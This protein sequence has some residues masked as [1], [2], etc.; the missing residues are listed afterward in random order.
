MYFQYLTVARQ[1]VSWAR[2][3]CTDGLQV[4]WIASAGGGSVS[5]LLAIRAKTGDSLRHCRHNM[6]DS[7]YDEFR[8]SSVLAISRGAEEL[9]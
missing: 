3:G 5:P 4:K 8:V 7:G 9:E 6:L 2:S 1:S